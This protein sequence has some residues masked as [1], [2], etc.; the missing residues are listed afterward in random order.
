MEQATIRF[1]GT[2]VEHVTPFWY[3]I[4]PDPGAVGQAPDFYAVWPQQMGIIPIGGRVECIFG[5]LLTTVAGGVQ[6]VT[7]VDRI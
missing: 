7:L 2:V 5:G 4:T 6:F 3:R 1:H